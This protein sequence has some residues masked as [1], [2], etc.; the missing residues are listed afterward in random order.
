MVSIT[1]HISKNSAGQSQGGPHSTYV[2]DA[3]MVPSSSSIVERISSFD[4]NEREF[5]DFTN[6][7]GVHHAIR[8]ASIG[9]LAVIQQ[10]CRSGGLSET[11]SR[12]LESSWRD[13]TKSTYESLFKQWDSWCQEQSRDPIRGPIADVLNFLAELFE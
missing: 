2:E 11:A 1:G 9:C 4:L 6:P 3:T 10:W 12:L 13:N 7:G 5:S 8:G